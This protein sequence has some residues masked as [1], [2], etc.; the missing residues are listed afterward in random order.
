MTYAKTDQAIKGNGNNKKTY[1]KLFI[2]ILDIIFKMENINPIFF[3]NSLFDEHSHDNPQHN[4][5][6]N[7][8]EKKCAFVAKSSF[9]KFLFLFS[10]Q[11]IN[12]IKQVSNDVSKT[13]SYKTIVI[14][15][16]RDVQELQEARK[17]KYAE[18]YK[19]CFF[20]SLEHIWK[21]TEA[22][23]EKELIKIVSPIFKKFNNTTKHER[24][25]KSFDITIKENFPIGKS[26]NLYKLKCES[27]GEANISPGQFV[28]LDTMSKEK[29]NSIADNYKTERSFADFSDISQGSSDLNI[30]RKSYLK[31]PFGIHRTYFKNFDNGYLKNFN[32]PQSL[33]PA[34]YTV[35][36]HEFDII[37]KVLPFGLGTNEMTKLKQNDVIKVIGPLGKKF[38]LREKISS[39]IDEVHI[40]GGGVG[41]APLIYIAQSLSFFNIKMKAFLGIE[42]LDSIIQRDQSHI[43]HTGDPKLVR[44]Y[45]DDLLDFMEKEDIYVSIETSKSGNERE[46]NFFYNTLI[47]VPYENY[48]SKTRKK[49]IAFAC[50]PNAMLEEIKEITNKAGIDLYVLLEKRMA[51]GIGVCFSCV[52][53]R[54]TDH[55]IDHSR[56]CVDGPIYNAKEI[57]LDEPSITKFIQ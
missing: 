57:I 26:L 10:F 49:V 22:I 27:F 19:R 12:T 56:V 21:H 9:H 16:F 6:L 39:K 4:E 48:T 47:S 18:K 14:I 28:M 20:T 45:I 3:N 13:G 17:I 42:S 24:G 36:P 23:N 38:N 40:I 55:G 31:R 50:G 7:N 1:C 8:I 25:I 15:I 34:L 54:K 35:Y 29:R 5:A 37:Y 11:N 53:K 32:L 43:G 41:M 30:I 2:N 51:C 44:I 46:N 52:C 33:A